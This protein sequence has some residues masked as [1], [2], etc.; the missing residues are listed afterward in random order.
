MEK[1][2]EIAR[3]GE[4][5]A[6][7]LAAIRDAL[8][9]AGFSPTHVHLIAA[10]SDPLWSGT[11]DRVFSWAEVKEV[12]N[13]YEDKPAIEQKR[14]VD[15]VTQSQVD[16]GKPLEGKVTYHPRDD[17]DPDADWSR[18]REDDELPDEDDPWTS[19]A[20]SGRTQRAQLNAVERDLQARQEPLRSRR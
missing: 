4:T 12:D 20:T 10:A 17:D 18:M 7:R 9:R 16:A 3:S 15:E 6:V 1:L 11:F 2:L 13:V 14:Q 8:D 19:A 5:E